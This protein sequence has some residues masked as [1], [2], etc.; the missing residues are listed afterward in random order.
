MLCQYNKKEKRMQNDEDPAYDDDF[1]IDPDVCLQALLAMTGDKE[2][3]EQLITRT[4]EKTGLP[5]EKV[6]VII[7]TSLDFLAKQSKSRS[8]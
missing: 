8:N 6:E 5:L 3:R 1:E 2:R 7:A 4:A